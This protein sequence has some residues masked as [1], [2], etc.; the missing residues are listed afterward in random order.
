MTWNVHKDKVISKFPPPWN[1]TVICIVHKDKMISKF[2]PPWN[3]ILIWN[4]HK[5]QMISKFHKIPNPV[6]LHIDLHCPQG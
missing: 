6:E 1:F 5:D 2:P 4:V 3:F